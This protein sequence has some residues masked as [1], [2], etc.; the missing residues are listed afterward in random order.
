MG[1]AEMPRNGVV[2]QP[3]LRVRQPVAVRRPHGAENL[4]RPREPVVKNANRRLLL[5][6]TYQRFKRL[7]VYAIF[8]PSGEPSLDKKGSEVVDFY[9]DPLFS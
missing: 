9:T 6:S 4:L 7:S 5:R 1:L 2:A 3:L 8:L